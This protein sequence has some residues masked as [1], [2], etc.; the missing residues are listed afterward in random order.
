MP[1]RF[2]LFNLMWERKYSREKLKRTRPREINNNKSTRL[3][4]NQLRWIE[5]SLYVSMI[6]ICIDLWDWLLQAAS[7]FLQRRGEPMGVH[8]LGC[9]VACDAYS[10]LMR[11][12]LLSSIPLKLECRSSQGFLSCHRWVYSY[13]GLS[14]GGSRVVLCRK[15]PGGSLRILII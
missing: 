12:G 3:L 9:G 1:V 4:S 2:K 10:F 7:L 11:E 14:F 5:W 6:Q 15:V 13:W 8:G